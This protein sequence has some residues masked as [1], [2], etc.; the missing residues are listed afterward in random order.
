MA[1]SSLSLKSDIPQHQRQVRSTGIAKRLF[2]MFL[3]LCPSI[4]PLNHFYGIAFINAA[5]AEAFPLQ[6]S[7]IFS[8]YYMCRFYF[9]MQASIA[10]A[11]FLP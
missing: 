9:A 3:F 11:S 7:L 6:P 5:R 10:S 4:Y 8:H 1:D 2:F